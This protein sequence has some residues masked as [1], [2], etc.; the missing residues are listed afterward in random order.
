MI[1]KRGISN[2]HQWNSWVISPS[3]HQPCWGIR[4]LT[5][6]TS[7]EVRVAVNCTD[8]VANGPFTTAPWNHW[9]WLEMEIE[10]NMAHHHKNRSWGQFSQ[11]QWISGTFGERRFKFIQDNIQ[12]TRFH[13]CCV[14]NHGKLPKSNPRNTWWFWRCFEKSEA[15]LNSGS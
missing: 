15:F 10:M 5:C 14:V 12:Y 3:T 9:R 13:G 4:G 8:P 2:L 11:N 6:D 7:Y 1:K